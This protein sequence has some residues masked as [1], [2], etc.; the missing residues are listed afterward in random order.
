MPIDNHHIRVLALALIKHRGRFLAC[1]GYDTVKGTAHYRLLGGGVEFGE[2]GV[3]AL[4]R[5][6]KEELGAMIKPPKLLGVE[7]NCFIFNGLPGHEI[8]FLYEVAF[9]SARWYKQES[10]PILDSDRGHR[11]EWISWKDLRGRKLYPLIAKKYL[12]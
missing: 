8:V 2:S 11:A 12:D 4:R 3:Q 5:E 1:A 6:L 10:F 9:S 7:E